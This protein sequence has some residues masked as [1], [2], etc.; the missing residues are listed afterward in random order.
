LSHTSSSPF[1]FFKVIFQV[2]SPEYF[3]L[4]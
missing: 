4:F 2:V 3:V 1:C